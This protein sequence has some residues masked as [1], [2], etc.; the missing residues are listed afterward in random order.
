MSEWVLDTHCDRGL[1][2]VAEADDHKDA[3]PFHA[4]QV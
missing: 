4:L 3:R 1:P 2:L